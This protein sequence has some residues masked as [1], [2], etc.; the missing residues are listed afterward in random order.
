MAWS[1]LLVDDSRI[2]RAVMKRTLE[3]AGVPVAALWEASGGEEALAVLERETVDLVFTDLM[4]PGMDGEALLGEMRRRGLVERIP[5]VVV[6]SAGG[7]PRERQLR[8]SG[9]RE[10]LRKPFTPEE[11]LAVVQRVM[12]EVT[13]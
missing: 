8:A 10:L 5:V 3:L 13:A 4:M 2:V 12:Q 1:I 6:S 9:A 7:T 11:V